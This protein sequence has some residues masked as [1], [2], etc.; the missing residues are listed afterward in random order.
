MQT[1]SDSS[2]QVSRE[3]TQE[4]SASPTMGIPEQRDQ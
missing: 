4:T 2:T 3:K 1:K